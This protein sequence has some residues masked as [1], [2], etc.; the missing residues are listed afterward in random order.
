MGGKGAATADKAADKATAGKRLMKRILQSSEAATINRRDVQFA[1]Y[2]PRQIAKPEFDRLV[3]SIRR[4]GLVDKPIVNRRSPAKGWADGESMTFIGGHQRIR[5]CDH[6]FGSEEY[7]LRVELIDVDEATERALN[8]ALNNPM[9]QAQF[10]LELLQQTVE[11]LHERGADLED[12]GYT[13]VE[14][15]Q[16]FDDKFVAGLFGDQAE[17]ESPYI[18]QLQAMKDAGR[19]AK[20]RAA[21]GELPPSS[22]SSTSSVESAPAEPPAPVSADDVNADLA[23]KRERYKDQAGFADTNFV[24]VALVFDDEE[25]TKS[26]FAYLRTKG[27]YESRY[28]DAE[29]F[30]AAVG[31]GWP[32]GEPGGGG[33]A[34]DGDLFAAER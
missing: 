3:A 25:Q 29:Q 22:V 11:W 26:F 33:D 30:A 4:F 5:A 15:S 8:V 24:Y 28:Y 12:T 18:E 34:E 14:F 31:L 20:S 19:E 7:E 23:R 9:L 17:E 21:G 13:R 6:V 32:G 16:M 10:D 1:P 27:L 2:N